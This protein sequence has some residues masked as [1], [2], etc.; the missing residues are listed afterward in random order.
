MRGEARKR[1]RNRIA[2]ALAVHARDEKWTDA[3][4]KMLLRCCAVVSTSRL[5]NQRRLRRP[6]RIELSSTLLLK[7]HE[8]GRP[9]FQRVHKRGANKLKG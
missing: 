5:S 6:A 3:K 1:A 2:M 7:A 4:R 9:T 8:V